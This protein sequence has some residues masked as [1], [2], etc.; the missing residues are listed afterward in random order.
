MRSTPSMISPTVP[1]STVTTSASAVI[2]RSGVGIK[3]DV[4]IL[5]LLSMAGAKQRLNVQSNRGSPGNSTLEVG[6]IRFDGRRRFDFYGLLGLQSVSGYR[7][8]GEI[9]GFDAALLDEFLSRRQGDA[10][11]RLR[12]YSLRFGEQSNARNDF[13]VG[14]I[15]GPPAAGGDDRS[16]V[17]AVCRISYCQRLRDCL[18][19][20]GLNFRRSALNGRDYRIASRGLRP[21]HAGRNFVLQQA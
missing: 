3:I 6:D 4:G 7:N 10:A 18:R 9:V 2:L 8:D 14:R 13:L 21:E 12:E 17:I 5:L 20:H 1:A 11:R 16:R 15:F 19:L